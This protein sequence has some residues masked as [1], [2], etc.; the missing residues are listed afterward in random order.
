MGRREELVEA[1]DRG[2]AEI[3]AIL[4]RLAPEQMEGPAI[5]ADGWSAKDVLWHLCCWTAEAARQLERVR[6]GTYVD[7]DWDTDGLNTRYLEK[8]RGQDLAT[9]R[10]E[11]AAA[12]SRMMAEWAAIEELSPPA[13][14]WFEESGALHYH[15]HLADLRA[16]ADRVAPTR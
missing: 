1:E 11:L 7:Q 8:G 3:Q 15:E 6:V 5:N 12:R 2:W 4:D 14:E 10:A 16:F 13:E 9:V